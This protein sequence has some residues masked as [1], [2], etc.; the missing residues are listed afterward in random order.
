MANIS[1]EPFDDEEPAVKPA[2]DSQSSFN[3]YNSGQVQH[4]VSG[5]NALKQTHYLGTEIER[6]IMTD[7]VSKN[8][9][10]V[11]EA[12]NVTHTGDAV[13]HDLTQLAQ[14][15]TSI[16]QAEKSITTTT[17][18]HT[19]TLSAEN[20]SRTITSSDSSLQYNNFAQTTLGSDTYV[21]N[22]T[23]INATNCTITGGSG[24]VKGTT[25]GGGGSQGNIKSGMTQIKAANNLAYKGN[26]IMMHP[27][28]ASSSLEIR[29]AQST[30]LL[31]TYQ[32]EK[33]KGTYLISD[34]VYVAQDQKLYFLTPPEGRG[35]FSAESSFIR[36]AENIEHSISSLRTAHSNSSPYLANAIGKL[37][38]A[39]EKGKAMSAAPTLKLA[40]HLATSRIVMVEEKTLSEVLMSVPFSAA[41]LQQGKMN[42]DSFQGPLTG[43]L[44]EPFTK[45]KIANE[46]AV[47]EAIE[48]LTTDLNDHTHQ[49]WLELGKDPRQNLLF[50]ALNLTDVTN[51]KNIPKQS[52]LPSDVQIPVP[53]SLA[54]KSVTYHRPYLTEDEQKYGIMTFHTDQV[55]YDSEP[56]L[57]DKLTFK[58]DEA[59]NQYQILSQNNSYKALQSQ[60]PKNHLTAAQLN[61]RMQP[62]AQSGGEVS[63]IPIGAY[64]AEANI[65]YPARTSSD[66]SISYSV[67][68]DTATKAWVIY[69]QTQAFLAVSDAKGKA[70]PKQ[71]STL[72]ANYPKSDYVALS[73]L[74][75]H[76]NF[77]T[78]MYYQLVHC[79]YEFPTTIIS[80]DDAEKLEDHYVELVLKTSG[81]NLTVAQLAQ[82]KSAD[83]IEQLANGI[84]A[85]PKDGLHPLVS[86]LPP[87]VIAK[88]VYAL[89]HLQVEGASTGEDSKTSEDISQAA[90]QLFSWLPS[91]KAY[92]VMLENYQPANGYGKMSVKESIQKIWE[93]SGLPLY[94]QPE[95]VTSEKESLPK[96]TQK[97]IRH[98]AV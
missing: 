12:L 77:E 80:K 24:Q 65:K 98:A 79:D 15:H 95:D 47:N 92:V 51:F 97:F 48:A 69:T 72:T 8:S 38:Q 49:A 41:D 45:I 30:Y 71:Q 16:T 34:V 29:K 18:T 81:L 60:T 70:G 94:S 53:F 25:V 59:T 75:D 19:H 61:W 63:N 17:E 82:N 7:Q 83:I 54:D 73:A 26:K 14:T 78:F 67:Q 85:L 76:Y 62:T 10:V 23:A 86:V 4:S 68:Y 33:A 52:Y 22:K 74:H 89:N 56:L 31:N 42:W 9:S 93:T 87:A 50:M 43:Q 57:E 20:L 66:E 37:N 11:T 58:L 64:Q 35:V 90:V 28:S 27:G 1:W 96:E 84:L 39:F 46:E 91:Q 36:A 44:K 88:L 13:K 32:T 40:L 5:K 3:A 2:D 55:A 6:V 21:G